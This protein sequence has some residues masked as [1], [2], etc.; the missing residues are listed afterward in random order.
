MLNIPVKIGRKIA[1]IRSDP[2]QYTIG[3]DLTS[4]NNK[5]GETETK[6]DVVGYYMSLTALLNALMK[7]KIRA[8][9]AR[10][11]EDLK[12]EIIKAKNDVMTVY[13]ETINAEIEEKG[14]QHDR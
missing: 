7:A 13:D 9:T 2:R 8:S 1:Y 4:V 11:L 5:T 6:Y 3:Y 10:T 14:E 12:K